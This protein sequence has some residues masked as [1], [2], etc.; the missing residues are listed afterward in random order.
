MKKVS[1]RWSS[2]FQIKPGSWVFVPTDEA[3]KYGNFIK[4]SIEARWSPPNYYYH[5]RDG[6]HVKALS[7]HLEHEFYIHLDI[8]NFFG[9]INKT[10]ATRSLKRYW[11]YDAAREMASQST[12]RDPNSL[13]NARYILPF[14]FVQSPI[15]ASLCLR[16][17]KLGS[18]LAKINKTAE[19]TVS[20]YMDDIIISSNDAQQ[21][22]VILANI[23]P[24]SE[25][26]KFPLN[27]KKEEG[28]SGV[29]T[30]FNI[31][32]SKGVLRLTNERLNAFKA[33]YRESDNFNVLSGIVGYVSTVNFDQANEIF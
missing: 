13:K 19:V 21:M 18:Y 31:K 2:K 30:A 20:V 16:N 6:G 11:S 32:L 8:S 15:I 24:I 17:S 33:A 10:R 14:G 5:L 12:V 22:A 23:K 3:V 29:I 27:P 7:S 1:Q 28:P 26:S 9:C 4:A 25:L